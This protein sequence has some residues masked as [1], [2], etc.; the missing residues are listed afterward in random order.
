MTDHQQWEFCELNVGGAKDVKG[1][2][3]FY[4]VWV[5]FMSPDKQCTDI[6]AKIDGKEARAFGYNPFRRAMALLGAAGWE[7]ISYQTASG[8]TDG[9]TG[10]I[11]W[12]EKI[13][14]FKRRVV[15][16]RVVDDANLAG[17][18]VPESS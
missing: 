2:G 1:K 10:H 4:D 14:V 7:M 11:N 3:A 17:L 16:G 5:Y 6:L 9:G 12:G 15:A 18:V 8:G 13:A